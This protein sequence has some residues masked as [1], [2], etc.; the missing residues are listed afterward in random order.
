MRSL[1]L[2][3][4]IVLLAVAPAVARDMLAPGF[5]YL[6]DVDSSI[7]QDI[8]YATHDN[9]TGDPF[10]ATARPSVCCGAKRRKRSNR[11]RPT[12]HGKTSA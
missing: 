4:L 6:R 2:L 9:F 7:T 8:R 10:P 3:L 12:W 5:V 1:P 11:F